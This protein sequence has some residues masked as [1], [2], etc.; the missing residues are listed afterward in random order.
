MS[1]ATIEYLR[2]LKPFQDISESDFNAIADKISDVEFPERTTILKQGEPGESMY[3]IKRGTVRVLIKAPNNDEDIELTQ[4]KDGDYFGEMALLTGESRSASIETVTP[5]ALLRLDKS[6][7]DLL[8]NENPKIALSLSH[9]LSKRLQATN[10]QLLESEKHYHDMIYPS[11]KLESINFAELL[12]FCEQNSLTGNLKLDSGEQK[13]VLKFDK[14][15]LLNVDLNGLTETESIDQLMQWEKGRFVI[16]PSIFTIEDE[17]PQSRPESSNE[18]KPERAEEKPD[19][20]EVMVEFLTVI[21]TRLV[22]VVGSQGLKDIEQKAHQQLDPF[23]PFLTTL[24]SEV[25]L[26]P[27]VSITGDEEW[28]EKK[29]LAIAVFLQY[30]IKSCSSKVVGMSFLDVSSYAGK[31][32]QVLESIAFFDYMAHADEFND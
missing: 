28:D 12:R 31:N 5:V 4:L 30:I 21:F 11:G 14:G 1:S 2:N 20:K 3:I 16:E 32:R 27:G 22:S 17:L 26:K 9:M 15:N 6:G 10:F 18:H 8:L 13:A 19:I 29:T 25:S 24:K 7:F 23:F